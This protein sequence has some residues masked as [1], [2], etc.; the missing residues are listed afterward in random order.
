VTT[1]LFLSSLSSPS[2]NSARG[3]AAGTLSNP[4]RTYTLGFTIDDRAS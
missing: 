3:L 4:T 2:G 1:S